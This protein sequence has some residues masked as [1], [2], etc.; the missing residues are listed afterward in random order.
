M[1]RRTPRF[2]TD[3]LRRPLGRRRLLG[4]SM[5]AGAGT[6]LGL[7][8]PRGGPAVAAPAQQDADTPLRVFEASPFNAGTPL[9]QLSGFLTP[10][11]L[12]F[13]RDHFAIPTIAS[14]DWTLTVDGAVTRPLE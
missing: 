8:A 14:G 3:S 11:G 4:G 10:N 13:V 2:V 1:A 5:L 6:A 9:E 12:F 7:L